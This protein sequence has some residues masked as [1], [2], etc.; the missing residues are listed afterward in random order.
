MSTP[1][2]QAFRADRTALIGRDRFYLQGSTVFRR[3]N[4]TGK[5]E[6][7]GQFAAAKGELADTLGGEGEDVVDTL[8][9]GSGAI[10]MRYVVQ[11]V[12]AAGVPCHWEQT[13]GGCGT[14]Y[15]GKARPDGFYPCVAGPGHYYRGTAHLSEFSI[16]VDLEDGDADYVSPEDLGVSTEEEIAAIVVAQAGKTDAA[17]LT[18]EEVAAALALVRP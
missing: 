10:D 11:L 2:P 5:V 8:D 3:D 17:S 1:I 4:A 15:A 7:V 13:G 16:S 6:E 14:L 12:Q 18:A 9:E